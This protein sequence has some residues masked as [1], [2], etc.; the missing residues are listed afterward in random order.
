MSDRI[1]FSIKDLRVFYG[2]VSVL[3][4]ISLQVETEQHRDPDRSQRGREEHH[5]SGRIRSGRH[6][7]RR[8]FI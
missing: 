1:W 7:R 3:K 4:G 2:T 5:P 8:D 6:R